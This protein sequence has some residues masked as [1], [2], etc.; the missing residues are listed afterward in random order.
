[1]TY[2]QQHVKSVTNQMLEFLRPAT[3][4]HVDLL[5]LA[6][7]E[8]RTSPKVECATLSTRR[9]LGDDEATRATGRR[10]SSPSN[11]RSVDTL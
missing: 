7:A 5:K 4:H 8:S 6:V 3:N 2:A 10:T 11:R 9:R 1:M